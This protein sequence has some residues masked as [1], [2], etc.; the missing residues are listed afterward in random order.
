MKTPSGR[1]GGRISKPIAESKPCVSSA[2][3]CTRENTH[4]KL[5][6]SLP[7]VQE[8]VLILIGAA[9]ADDTEAKALIFRHLKAGLVPLHLRDMAFLAIDMVSRRTQ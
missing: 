9:L 2:G 6:A 1:A 7:T 4:S 5:T 8:M 3:Q